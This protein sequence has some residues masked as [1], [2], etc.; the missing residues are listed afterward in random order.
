MRAAS[1][2]WDSPV[3]ND[4]RGLKLV[5][6]AGAVGPAGDSP[7]SNDGRG[8][9]RLAHLGAQLVEVGFARQQ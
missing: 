9:K 4:G 3:S 1:A 2:S 8:L 6:A 5:G 7:V